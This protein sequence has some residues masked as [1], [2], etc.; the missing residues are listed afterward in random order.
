MANPVANVSPALLF[1]LLCLLAALLCGCSKNA[2]PS[3]PAPGPQLLR[4]SQRN[5]PGDLDPARVTAPDEFA[6]LRALLEGLLMPGPNGADPQ[7]GAA[8]RFDVSPDGLTYTFHLRRGA[9][10]SNG[11]P[12]TAA[13]FAASFRRVLTPATA[14]PKASVFFPIK[15]AR[16]FLSG[17]LTDFAAVGIAA[18]DT[19]T[20]VLTLEHPN[21]K[22]PHYVASGP[23]LPVHLPTV[24]KHG[25]KWTTPENFVGNGP[26]TLAEWRPQQRLILRKNSR[27]HSAAT[28]RLAEIHLLRFDSADTE[29]RAFRAGQLEATV[30]IP[31]A[32]IDVYARERPAD[33]HRAP[34]IETRY[35][36]FNTRRP[37]L[38]DAQVRRALALAIDRQKLVDRVTRGEQ[39][40]AER[41]VPPALAPQPLPPTALHRHDPAAARQ[42]LAGRTLP[43]LELTA[44]SASQIPV[45][46]ALQAMWRETLGVDVAISVRELKVH[47]DALATGNFDLAFISAI[48]DVADPANLLGDFATGAPENYPHLSD[49]AFDA[50][51]TRALSLSDPAARN[52]ALSAAEQRLLETAAVT[53]LYFN[54]KIW[55]M[56]P[57]VRGWQEDGLWSRSYHQISLDE[58]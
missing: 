50:A 20:L 22:F 36:A 46:E 15:N 56:S 29:D 16:A 23:F 7:P 44:W 32:K 3:A 31:Q 10:W 21:P 8:S 49:P 45:I 58:K 30:G 42:L 40:I 28:V 41:F 37:A 43:R 35:V 39:P 53:P 9:T 24:E 57:R 19:H 26:F 1:R 54:T 6:I 11:A 48:P 55:L 4:L 34:M 18:P 2:S 27:Y 12:V 17:Q 14:S 51:Y 52:A 47:L 25:R 38:A 33:L 5:E 13:D